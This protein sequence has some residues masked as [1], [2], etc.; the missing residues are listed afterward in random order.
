MER[1]GK[2]EAFF[3]ATC[4]T[5]RHG[6]NM[7]YYNITQD[8]VQMPPFESFRDAESYYATLAYET[9]HYAVSLIMPHGRVCRQ[10][11]LVLAMRR[12]GIIRR[13]RGRR[14]VAGM[15]ARGRPA[16]VPFPSTACRR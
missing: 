4:A 15:I 16:R 2:A 8:F 6:G 14:V 11:R 7:A 5:I 13:L 9:T 12:F 10:L 3:A 1:I